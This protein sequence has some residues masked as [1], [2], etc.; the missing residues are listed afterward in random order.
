MQYRQSQGMRTF[1]AGMDEVYNEFSYGMVD[2]AAIRDFL[3]YAFENWQSPAP[4]YVFLLGD[5]NTDI[6]DYLGTGKKSRVPS[7]MIDTSGVGL[8]PEDNWYVCVQGDD[9]LPDMLV[10]RAPSGSAQM[11]AQIVQKIL[12]YESSAFEPTMALFTADNETQ[13]EDQ[14][15]R[16]I[17]HLP[18]DFQAV[19]V[20]QRLLGSGAK[21]AIIDAL[22]DG[23]L[24]TNYSGHGS[25]TNWASTPTMFLSSDI[26]SLSNADR[27]SFVTMM[28]CINGYYSHPDGYCMAEEFVA[29]V[30]KGGIGTFAPSGLGYLWEQNILADEF[31]AN[32]YRRGLETVGEAATDAKIRAFNRGMSE[33]G[34]SFYTLFCEPAV[35]LKIDLPTIPG[36][37]NAD[38]V[39]DLADVQIQLQISTGQ[40]PS[41][42]Y[43]L[44]DVDSDGRV[45]AQE[46]AYGLRKAL[47]K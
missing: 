38:G 17:E 30:D 37:L 45:G 13:F 15:E 3:Q 39:V 16:L 33:L 27:L 40:S 9:C 21:Q 47:D 5:A 1:V 28:T 19:R 4:L 23:M 10:G 31:Y 44:A 2:P 42:F 34:V 11:A 22:N 24:T 36:D 6:R 32:V 26:A 25:L 29:A 14:N 41:D 12:G 8:T 7:H 35:K 20:Y 43:R 46:G 18:A